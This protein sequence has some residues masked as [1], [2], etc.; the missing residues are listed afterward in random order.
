MI[1]VIDGYNLLHT[2][3]PYKKTIT[4]QERKRFVTQLGRYG[5]IKGHKIVLF[6]DGGPYEWPV[7]EK[8][9]FID[10]IYSGIYESADDCIKEYIDKQRSRDILLV[11]SDRELNAYA[12]QHTVPSIDSFAFYQLL[13]EVKNQ[14]T[15]KSA[16]SHNVVKTTGEMREDIDVLMKNVSAWGPEK[17]EDIELQ[18]KNR[19][20]KKQHLSKHERVLL[21]KLR[22]L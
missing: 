8:M 16:S 1:I 14:I 4:D 2:V 15:K 6:F 3:P 18:E 17:A 12:A 5:H 21:K 7:K 11:T 20:S 22:K 19:A 10:V 13:Q 9:S